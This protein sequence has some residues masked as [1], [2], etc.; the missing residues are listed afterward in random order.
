MGQQSTDSPDSISIVS[1]V[2][3][4]NTQVVELLIFLLLCCSAVNKKVLLLIKVT[5]D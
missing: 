1:N 3:L 2:G 4:Q 5:F